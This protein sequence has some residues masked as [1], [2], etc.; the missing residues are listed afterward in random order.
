MIQTLTRRE[1]AAKLPAGYGHVVVDECHHVTAVSIERLLRDVPARHV[2]GLTA[3]PRR[4]DGHHPI[5]A[6]Q[7]GPVRH[8]L[9]TT[10]AAAAMVRR[11]AIE[12]P[13]E[14]DPALLPADPAIQEILGAVAAGGRYPLVL[15]ERRQHLQALASLLEPSPTPLVTLHGRMG[16]R[17]RRAR[18][19]RR[20]ERHDHPVRRT[21]APPSRR[22]RGDPDPRLCRSRDPSAAPDVRKRRRAY[23]RLG[24][25]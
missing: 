22:Q 8:T 1:D 19:A 3:T 21:P 15:T 25:R 9:T 16:V 17:A 12:R 7:C 23:D 14:L 6:M 24:Y 4:R 11:V 5:I 20:L 10:P 13:T 18:N 2:T